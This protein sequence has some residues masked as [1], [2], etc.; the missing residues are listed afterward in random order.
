[1]NV[2]KKILDDENLKNLA[3]RFKEITDMTQLKEKVKY[4]KSINRW[5]IMVKAISR[6]IPE[7]LVEKLKT[8]K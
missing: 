2:A 8:Q 5:E 6:F 7:F 4:H 1:M 3:N